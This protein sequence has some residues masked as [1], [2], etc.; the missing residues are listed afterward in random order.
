[1]CHRGHRQP[2]AGQ[3]ACRSPCARAGGGDR[4]DERRAR[5]VAG[6]CGRSA[7]DM[8]LKLQLAILALAGHYPHIYAH[9]SGPDQRAEQIATVLADSATSH[10]VRPETLVALAYH[11]SRFDERAVSS[12]GAVGILQTLTKFWPDVWIRCVQDPNACLFWQG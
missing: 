11:E 9:P 5:R 1:G 10:G 7:E 2:P 8:I 4:E 3:G 6:F 12:V